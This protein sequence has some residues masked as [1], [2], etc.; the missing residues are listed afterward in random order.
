MWWS[1]SGAER[2]RLKKSSLPADDETARQRY[3]QSRPEI[4]PIPQH[5]SN[6]TIRRRL[7]LLIERA[8]R[9]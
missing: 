3:S 4:T 6:G 5:E 9:I 1:K 8:Q 2:R 7:E